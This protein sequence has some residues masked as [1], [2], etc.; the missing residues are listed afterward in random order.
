MFAITVKRYNR[1]AKQKQIFTTS[2]KSIKIYL[3]NFKKFLKQ[4]AFVI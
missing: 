4:L 1:E 2:N 3:T